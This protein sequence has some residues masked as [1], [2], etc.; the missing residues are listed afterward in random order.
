MDPFQV[1][2]LQFRASSYDIGFQIG[3]HLKNS[4]KLS[5]F[6]QIAKDNIN[7][8][9]MEAILRGFSPNLVEELKGI[10]DGMNVPYE[11][12]CALFSGYDVPK[13]EAMGCTSFATKE[14]YVR[15]YDFSPILYD[16]IFTFSQP[17][18]SFASAG[19]NLQLLGRHDG[20][21]EKGLV[22]GLHFVSNN[23]YRKG[24]QSWVAVRMILETCSNVKEAINM[25]K[26]VPHAACYNFSLSDS[27]GQMVVVEASPEQVT[28][29][30]G[31]QHLSCENHFKTEQMRN[32]NRKSMNNSI[33]RD[34][35]FQS[36]NFIH[37][38]QQMMF[39][40][41]R[42][43]NSPLFFT[44]YEQLFGTLHTFSYRFQDSRLLISVARSDEILNLK[45]DEWVNGK[46]VVIK[47]LNGV[48]K[49]SLFKIK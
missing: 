25:L 16:G 41:F 20:V 36:N 10:A 34:A 6:K 48:I 19:F 13:T 11:K 38:S 2:V 32:Y 23:G 49:P 46:N 27:N 43:P 35:Y 37:Y 24:I 15:N 31:E 14:F 12:A 8:K 30:N 45:M 18:T 5:I 42:N 3:K 21:N 33:K 9:E 7:V 1:D 26:E 4:P 17:A 40:H 39:D 28:I 22:A 29:R 47:S 44:E